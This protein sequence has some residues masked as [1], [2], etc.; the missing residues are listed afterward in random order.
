MLFVHTMSDYSLHLQIVCV[1]LGT[2]ETTLQCRY[3]PLM[4]R[5][6]LTIYRDSQYQTPSLDL[7]ER[8]LCTN[9]YPYCTL[10]YQL[11]TSEQYLW[12]MMVGNLIETCTLC[13]YGLDSH[14]AG[15][16][17]SSQLF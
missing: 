2:L 5:V 10:F 8:R 17:L 6:L 4:L 1:H 16:V 15:H 11:D 9:P 14:G 7:T 12:K 13:L 3:T